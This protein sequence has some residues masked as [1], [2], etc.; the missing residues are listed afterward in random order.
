MLKCHPSK[1]APLPIHV[2]ELP[3]RNDSAIQPVIHL[4]MESR[5]AEMTGRFCM[6]FG[7]GAGLPFDNK[8]VMAIAFG[9]PPC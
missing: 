6:L 1:E 4:R 5:N 7:A 2:F 9:L 8:K 3:T